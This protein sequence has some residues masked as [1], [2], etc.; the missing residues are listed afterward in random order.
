MFPHADFMQTRNLTCIFDM[1]RRARQ[2][3]IALTGPAGPVAW[4]RDDEIIE[5][6][7]TAVT[8][9]HVAWADVRIFL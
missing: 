2:H 7:A 4:L 8:K 5:S 6:A 1:S 9:L 3:E